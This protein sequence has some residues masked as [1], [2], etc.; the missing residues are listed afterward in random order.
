M[1]KIILLLGVLL[2]LTSCQKEI[3]ND[4][5]VYG[6]D[7]FNGYI[8]NV[9]GLAD[10]HENYT[11]YFAD[12]YA[13]HSSILD[14]SKTSP[15]GTI[16]VKY[17]DSTV[18]FRLSDKILE[19]NVFDNIYNKIDLYLHGREFKIEKG[20]NDKLILTSY[21]QENYLTG[22]IEFDPLVLTFTKVEP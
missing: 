7:Y 9:D 17:T 5:S 6:L 12:D 3:P 2:T 8:F 10:N 15:S 16:G 21:T 4:V 20:K 19:G 18:N 22:E 11:I 1:K 14:Y 13:L